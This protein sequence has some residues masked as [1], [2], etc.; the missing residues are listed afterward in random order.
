MDEVW[1]VDVAHQERFSKRSKPYTVTDHYYATSFK[2]AREIIDKLI[3]DVFEDY[4]DATTPKLRSL[5]S[6]REYLRTKHK[7]AYVF[8]A[9]HC[10]SVVDDAEYIW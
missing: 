9:P 5:K 10:E 8:Y 4:R 7:D 6:K 3:T 1:V 2:V